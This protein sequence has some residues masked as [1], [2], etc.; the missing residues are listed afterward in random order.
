MGGQPA[1]WKSPVTFVPGTVYN[2]ET[3]QEMS[4]VNFLD[5][6]LRALEGVDFLIL[7]GPAGIG[8]TYG[9]SLWAHQNGYEIFIQEC[10][11]D[12]GYY[13][14]IGSNTMGETGGM[15]FQAGVVASAMKNAQ[16]G[17]KTMLVLDE[18]NLLPEAVLKAIGS[19]FD[20]RKAVETPIGRLYGNG[21]LK[22]VG[23]CNSEQES[24]GF[25]LDIALQSRAIIFH[26]EAEEISKRFIREKMVPSK[27]GRLIGASDG[28][29][30]LREVQQVMQLAPI[31]GPERAM[32][33]VTRKFVSEERKKL[34]SNAVKR[35]Y[36]E[37]QGSRF[38]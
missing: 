4:P 9:P 30:S 25:E 1:N 27:T 8:K 14:L 16:D 11:G 17:K 24:A 3:K 36:G 6:E 15:V 38:V 32:Q 34:V 23:T 35:V 5:E 22:I 26:L 28:A 13:D 20:Y 29:F 12:M 7:R 10:S 2:V 21:N 18:V 37:E 33:I 31:Y 19:V